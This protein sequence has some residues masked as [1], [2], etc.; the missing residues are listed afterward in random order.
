MGTCAVLSTDRLNLRPVITGDAAAFQRV[1]ADR[2]VGRHTDVPSQPSPKRAGGIVKA[3]MRL[4]ETGKGRAWAALLEDEIV[5]FWRLNT[6]DKTSAR[7]VIGY[8]L[9]MSHWGQGLGSEATR[10]VVAHGHDDLDLFRLEAEVFAGNLAS[11]GVLLKAGF[12]R[13]GTQRSRILHQGERRDL[14][15]FGRLAQDVRP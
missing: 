12:R 2:D 10:A 14:W 5:G 13:E 8:E 7:A 15:L 11:A 4:N 9:A 6:I 3:M 1:M